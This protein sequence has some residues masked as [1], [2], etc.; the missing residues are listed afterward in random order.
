MPIAGVMGGAFRD[1]PRTW[2]TSCNIVI[3]TY[4]ELGQ[5]PRNKMA[6]CPKGFATPHTP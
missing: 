5:P 2:K 3:W 1:A 4:S 6:V